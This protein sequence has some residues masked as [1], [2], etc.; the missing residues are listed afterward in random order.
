MKYRHSYHAGNFADIHKH[1]ALLAL[2]RAMKRKEKPF[3]YLETHGGRGEYDAPDL[4]SGPHHTLR[5]EAAS[6][7][8]ETWRAD[9][10]REY[11]ALVA[12]FR[13]ARRRAQAYPG[14]PL[15]AA[16]EL[17]AHDRAAVAE[18]IPAEARQ[19]ARALR[20]YTRIQ[21]ETDDGF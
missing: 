9:E 18:I 8:A 5:P 15:I 12:G 20:G 10:L 2:L 19:L 3:A 7:V 17:R 21:V 14:S 1:V 4:L 16:H 11:A 13:N 6:S